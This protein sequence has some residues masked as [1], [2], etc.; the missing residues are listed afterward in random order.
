MS[1]FRILFRIFVVC[2][3]LLSAPA[4]AADP[5]LFAP[6]KDNNLAELT[7]MVGRDPA[8]ISQLSDQGVSPLLF[9]VYNE[10]YEMANLLR[11]KTVKLSIFEACVMGDT[12]SVKRF[13]TLGGDI[14][15]RSSDGFTPLGLSV[16]FRQ[17][18][19][20]K[21]LIDAGA[22]VDAKATNSLQVAPIHAAV[23]RSDLATLQLLL[24]AGANPNLTQ[25]RLMRPL[26]EAAAA[27]NLPAVAMLLLFGADP[28]ARNEE[29]KDASDFARQAGH[30]AIADRISVYVS[31]TT[32]Q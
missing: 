12:G 9:A 6:I 32:A 10:R 28:K 5:A 2:G 26:H 3:V 21:L 19:I 17:P 20:A 13:I 18:S 25:Q 31:H 29:G 27:G 30:P 14:N 4:N 15:R 23:A 11:A 7:K 24:E 22:D 8:L 1:Y 16:F